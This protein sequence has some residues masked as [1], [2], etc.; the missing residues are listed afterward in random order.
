M[1]AGLLYRVGR[2]FR[3]SVVFQAS[4]LLAKGLVS[5]FRASA[6]SRASRAS[7][8]D[9]FFRLALGLTAGVPI[10][11]V[12][13]AAPVYS[14]GA[15][16]CVVSGNVATV[17]T[18]TSL[19]ISAT[20][21][22]FGIDVA[23]GQ[24]NNTV[25]SSGTLSAGDALVLQEGAQL[26]FGTITADVVNPISLV[27]DGGT[28][29]A[30]VIDLAGENPTI[31]TGNISGSLGSG[32]NGATVVADAAQLTIVNSGN[33]AVLTFEEANTYA[34][35][36][37]L[38]PAATKSLTVKIENVLG[39]GGS[40]GAVVINPRATVD[41]A[42]AT[43][44]ATVANGWVLQ[45]GVLK[46]SGLA[47]N[48]TLI[49]SGGIITLT[50]PTTVIAQGATGTLTTLKLSG[51]I[52][53]DQNLELGAITSGIGTVELSGDNSAWTG[54]IALNYGGLKLSSAKALSSSSNIGSFANTTI[55][56]S[57]SVTVG[58]LD[59]AGAVVIDAG[60]T[61]TTDSSSTS[62]LDGVI[63]GD[64]GFTKSG[65][66]TAT[67]G[68]QSNTYAGL[69]TVTGGELKFGSNNSIKSGNSVFISGGTLNL[70][71]Y[72]PTLNVT[73]S[74]GTIS[75][76]VA[77]LGQLS[78]SLSSVGGTITN[79]KGD[80]LLSQ[81]R[82]VTTLTG[83]NQFN[84]ITMDGGTIATTI[85]GDGVVPLTNTGGFDYN[86]GVLTV[87]AS[88][89]SA[90]TGTWTVIS[91]SVDEAL[92]RNT[93]VTFQGKT[94]KFE[95]FDTPIAGYALY[96][97]YLKKGSLQFV[98]D[99]KSATDV[100]GITG[101]CAGGYLN[102]SLE[103]ADKNA[104]A[105]VVRDV[106]MPSYEAG[107]LS[108]DF[109]TNQENL[110]KFV[111]SGLMPRNV[112]AAGNSLANYNELLADTLFNRQPLRK[113]QTV[114]TV[115][116]A[117]AVEAVETSTGDVV[118]EGVEVAVASAEVTEDPNLAAQYLEDDKWGAWV[119]GFGG[120]YKND[121]EGT[122]VYRDYSATFGGV[123]LGVDYEVASDVRV[124]AYANNGYI[125]MSQSSGDYSGSGSWNPTGW[126]GGI[127]ASYV[128]PNFYVQGLFGASG[129]SGTQKRSL[130][131]STIAAAQT[132]EAEKDVTSFIGSLRF[133]APVELGKFIL[134]PQLQATWTG[135]QESAF[136]ENS[137]GNAK[138][139]YASRSTNFLQTEL[140]AKLTMP[141]N[142]GKKSE[143]VPNIRVAWLG[144][145][146]I[147]GEG[148]QV[149]YSFTNR[150]ATI[151]SENQNDMGVLIE[152]G[153]DYTIANTESV[154]YKVYALGGVELFN[155]TGGT[156]WRA[157]G[158]VKFN[159]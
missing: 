155:N 123:L 94:L 33:A 87:D 23:T 97:L 40:L 88:G 117:S 148:Q 34:G 140:G 18:A 141:I 143:I 127:T 59:N 29:T 104:V 135:N 10:A 95:G 3:F 48:E 26:D 44:G 119:K 21:T 156:G 70:D 22:L 150:T 64:G 25:D 111:V 103:G 54:N 45:G 112:D 72:N 5:G 55:T 68:S 65:T 35:V 78:G 83:A 134:D 158:G 133:G 14:A 20:G 39:F 92:A 6:A 126:G 17:A 53:G 101:L 41:L 51:D 24:C 110:S 157:S 76:G 144:D 67:F 149:G 79:V 100:C 159:F 139:S 121:G 61:L 46:N 106:L 30:V 15:A 75:G 31:N 152:G 136:N 42:I 108:L 128:K 63:S 1:G 52:I 82:G 84:G 77:S 151:D 43:N 37:N 38:E 57:E 66:G 96:D 19:T 137:G 109:Y 131:S 98:S 27:T 153:V 125:S 4:P 32:A 93:E 28:A 58:A 129:F 146:G 145:W 102:G 113:F 80:A 105:G 114:E 12:S 120:D 118:A 36:Y 124:G 142:I 116:E 91:G 69:T 49:L 86:A 13:S 62:A 50:A 73:L 71:Q 90:Q 11:V 74:G 16:Q 2:I 107:D 130:V 9:K 122:Y 99:R 132:I 154:S 60:K 8:R 85:N 7:R 56:V 89:I 115:A 147:N 138:L 81:V 47:N